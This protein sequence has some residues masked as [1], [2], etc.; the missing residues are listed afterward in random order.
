MI[1]YGPFELPPTT[2][3]FQKDDQKLL[4][5]HY[6]YGQPVISVVSYDRAAE[7]SHWGDNLNIQDNVHIRNDG[8]EY[9]PTTF[10]GIA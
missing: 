6:E 5:I 9:V 4:T 3:A 1:T 10:H 8:P 2:G 7:I